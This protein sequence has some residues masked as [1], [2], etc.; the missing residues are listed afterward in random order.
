MNTQQMKVS[1]ANAVPIVDLP[2]LFRLV[3]LNQSSLPNGG[4]RFQATLFNEKASIAVTWIDSK[5]DERLSA[6][7]LVTP[8]CAISNRPYLKK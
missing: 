7:C 3:H 1:Q 8:R 6:G 2:G 5:V 4:Y